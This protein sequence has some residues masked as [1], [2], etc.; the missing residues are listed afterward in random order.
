MNNKYLIE[1]T[2]LAD[3]VSENKTSNRILVKFD[4]NKVRKVCNII[5]SKFVDSTA[6]RKVFDSVLDVLETEDK[7]IRDIKF[8]EFKSFIDT[9]YINYNSIDKNLKE[10]GEKEEIIN[11]NSFNSSDNNS[12]TEKTTEI[13]TNKVVVHKPIAFDEEL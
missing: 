8:N 4:K 1:L 6:I 7:E 5:N 9:I 11:R 10:D 3:S 12:N 13:K 2:E